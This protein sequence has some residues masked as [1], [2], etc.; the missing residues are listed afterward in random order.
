MGRGIMLTP[1]S[2]LVQSLSH[3]G[4]FATPWTAA[5]QA[6]LSI[7]ISWSLLLGLPF[8]HTVGHQVPKGSSVFSLPPLDPSMLEKEKLQDEKFLFL[9]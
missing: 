6:S 5:S 2:S 7:T 1:G 9:A 8:S 3:V 4:L